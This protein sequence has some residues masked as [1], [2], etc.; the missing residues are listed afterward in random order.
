MFFT[1]E[2]K[3][4]LNVIC[5]SVNKNKSSNKTAVTDEYRSNV[6]KNKIAECDELIFDGVYQVSLIYF[7]HFFIYYMGIKSI[8][9]TSSMYFNTAYIYIAPNSM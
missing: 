6:L 8:L 2:K 4:I 3:H 7:Y 5:F 9:I 1:L